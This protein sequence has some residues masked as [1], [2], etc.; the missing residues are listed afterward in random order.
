MTGGAAQ[1]AEAGGHFSMRSF[2]R[3]LRRLPQQVG[4]RLERARWDELRKPTSTQVSSPWMPF[5]SRL[6]R[7]REELADVGR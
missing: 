2:T 3:P 5:K 6:Q 1:V 7:P 4:A